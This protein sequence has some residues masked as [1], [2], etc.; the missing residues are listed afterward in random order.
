MQ[1]KLGRMS[2][3]STESQPSQP[4]KADAILAE[5]PCQVP[6]STR[7]INGNTSP[8]SP[9]RSPVIKINFNLQTMRRH[10]NPFEG[11]TVLKEERPETSY[12]LP[13]SALLSPPI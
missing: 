8:N 3:P 13:V 12:S 1:K 11:R 5:G 9:V 4:V 10:L 7:T 6:S 2:Q